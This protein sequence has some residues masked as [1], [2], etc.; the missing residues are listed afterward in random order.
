M[1]K[2]KYQLIENYM[3]SCA[4]D[5]AHD[6]EHIYRVLYNAL[7]I[8]KTE[9][10]VDYDILI[11]ACLLHD[12]ARKEQAED[13]SVCHATLGSEKAYRFLTDN[14]FDEAFAEKVRH[15]IKVHR[16]RKNTPPESIEAKILFDA[17]KLDVSGAIGIARTLLYQGAMSEPLYSLLP[18]GT[19]SN[20]E[21]DPEPSFFQ[22]YKFKLEKIYSNF[23][24]NEGKRLAAEKQRSAIVFYNDLFNE[25]KT[26]YE[27]G[28]TELKKL[29]QEQD[30]G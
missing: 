11:S 23:F 22:E 19:P 2:E 15:C 30:N 4:E 17:D 16:F 24:T 8:A 1:N 13:P 29:I 6:K 25:I 12:I 9:G 7:T 10:T 28:K 14:G 26:P 20:G 5:S 18:D 3:I 27:K 21:N